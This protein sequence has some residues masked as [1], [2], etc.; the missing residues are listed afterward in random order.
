M[1]LMTDMKFVRREKKVTI[2]MSM[3]SA[4]CLL[5][6]MQELMLNQDWKSGVKNP[7]HCMIKFEKGLQLSRE[8]INGEFEV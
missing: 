2:T 1:R 7:R 4:E 5:R 8:V 3:I 6:I